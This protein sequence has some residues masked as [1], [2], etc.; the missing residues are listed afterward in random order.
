MSQSSPLYCV[1]T[2]SKNGKKFWWFYLTF[3]VVKEFE[4]VT[5]TDEAFAQFCLQVKTHI[6][7]WLILLYLKKKGAQVLFRL[8]FI[9]VKLL[10]NPWKLLECTGSH[11]RTEV[12]MQFLYFLLSVLSISRRQTGTCPVPSTATSAR[13]ARRQRPDWRLQP[14]L[15]HLNPV[16]SIYSE[17]F[18]LMILGRGQTGCCSQFLAI[19]TQ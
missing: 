14:I 7:A 11:T 5:N 17:L 4:G 13:C 3:I 1:P 2:V 16:S 12:S 10:Q 19:S 9:Q 15:R 6:F 18:N 8:L